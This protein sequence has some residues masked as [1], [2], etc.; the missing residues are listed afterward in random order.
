MHEGEIKVKWDKSRELWERSQR[1]LAGGI[2]S[3]A[4]ADDNPFPLFFE[5]GEGSRIVD[6][7]GNEYIDYLLGF[8]PL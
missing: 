7:D 5:R 2:S 3:L 8:G 4:R 6:V 1:S